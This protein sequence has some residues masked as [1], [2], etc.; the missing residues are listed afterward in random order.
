MSTSTCLE[1]F[2][3]ASLLVLSVIHCILSASQTKA[4]TSSH[5]VNQNSLIQNSSGNSSNVHNSNNNSK[6]NEMSIQICD[7]SHPC[8]S[9]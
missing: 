7:K 6:Q 4:A 1:K 3:V 2:L 5:P 8:K 9:R